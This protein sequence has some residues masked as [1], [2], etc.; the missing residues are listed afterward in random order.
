MLGRCS[1]LQ[2][3][4]LAGLVSEG[5][6]V[7][8]CVA[9]AALAFE[10]IGL[11]TLLAAGSAIWAW[12]SGMALTATLLAPACLAGMAGLIAARA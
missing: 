10:R 2:A 12:H 6:G 7:G 9:A 4:P 1:G 8:L 11:A 5:A 3:H